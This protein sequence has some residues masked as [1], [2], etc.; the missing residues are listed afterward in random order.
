MNILRTFLMH[1]AV[2]ACLASPLAGA[3]AFSPDASDL[4]WNPNESGWG[5]QLVQRNG[6]IFATLYVFSPAGTPTWYVAAMTP[7]PVPFTWSGDLFGSTGPWLGT[8]PFN[9]QLVAGSKVGTMSW[10]MNTVETGTLTYSVNGIAVQKHL[11]RQ[12][13]AVVDYAGTYLGALHVQAS[14]CNNAALDGTTDLAATL[15]VTEQTQ[16][17][18]TMVTVHAA[19]LGGLQCTYGGTLAQY[20]QMGQVNGT[21]SCNNT[22]A[23]TFR[24]SEFQVNGAGITGRMTAKSSTLGCQDAAWFGAMRHAP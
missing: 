22:D 24:I 19:F 17:G 14:Q 3:T 8:V 9:P 11:T 4:Y 13:L 1:V 10:T 15:Q 21:Y 18:G 2:A 23:G 7:Q 6:L 12:T 20:G 5:M 16:P